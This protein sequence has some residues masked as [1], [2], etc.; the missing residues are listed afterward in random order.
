[1]KPSHRANKS[2]RHRTTGIIPPVQV[3]V[4]LCRTLLLG[5]HLRHAPHSLEASLRRFGQSAIVGKIFL[6]HATFDN[7]KGGPK[8]GWHGNP[9]KGSTRAAVKPDSQPG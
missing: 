2:F 5:R 7:R 9:E 6:F 3:A 8:P 4:R 1:M